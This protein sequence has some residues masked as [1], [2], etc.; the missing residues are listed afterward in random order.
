MTRVALLLARYRVA[1]LIVLV[2]LVAPA[3]LRYG[4][5]VW[6]ACPFWTPAP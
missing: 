3:W 1:L 2:L 5:W 4:A 6:G